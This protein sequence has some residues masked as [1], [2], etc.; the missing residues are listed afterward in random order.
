MRKRG[1]DFLDRMRRLA[2]IAEL[3]Q[4][5]GHD[6]VTLLAACSSAGHPIKECA[7]RRD[8]GLLRELGAP[9]VYDVPRGGY[10]LGGRWSL[11]KAIGRALAGT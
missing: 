2:L 7:I 6:T 4:S 5:G 9:V 8:L 11:V 1:V 10:R 3:I